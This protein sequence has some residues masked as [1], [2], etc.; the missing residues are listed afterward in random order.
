MYAPQP[1]PSTGQ[2]LIRSVMFAFLGAFAVFLGYCGGRVHELMITGARRQK[3]EIA[4]ID[5][6]L[7]KHPDRYGSLFFNRGPLHKFL[8]EGKVRS[9]ADRD[10]LRAEAT[11]LFGEARAD[12]IMAVDTPR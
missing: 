1:A 5:V 10:A 2:R 12:E 11:R 7:K 9:R 3:Y 4:A 8:V 6:F